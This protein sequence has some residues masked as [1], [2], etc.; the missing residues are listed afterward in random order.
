[1]TVWREVGQQHLS[2]TFINENRVVTHSI[3]VVHGKGRLPVLA[4]FFGL[5]IGPVLSAFATELFPTRIR[6]Q[7][8][9]WVRNWFAVVGSALGPPG[10]GGWENRTRRHRQ[11]R[12]HPQPP[13][14]RCPAA[15]FPHMA[16]H[17]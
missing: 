1:M 2:N 7:P 6:A 11:Y 17:A 9:S 16:L 13:H 5:G 15:C 8:S 14:A 12:Q 10:R 4:V 3:D